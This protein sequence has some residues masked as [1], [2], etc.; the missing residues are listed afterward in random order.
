MFIEFYVYQNGWIGP[1]FVAFVLFKLR[2][3]SCSCAFQQGP[4]EEFCHLVILES[5]PRIRCLLLI[6]CT[7]QGA[8]DKEKIRSSNTFD[9]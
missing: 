5:V 7:L 9:I 6:V 1:L 2:V 4:D 3:Y 8:L